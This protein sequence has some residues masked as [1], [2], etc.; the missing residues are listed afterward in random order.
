MATKH[1]VDAGSNT[2]SCDDDTSLA[3]HFAARDYKAKIG[4]LSKR[5]R[6]KTLDV[7]WLKHT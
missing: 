1:E 6:K 3:A 7:D 4:Q 2:R 5:T